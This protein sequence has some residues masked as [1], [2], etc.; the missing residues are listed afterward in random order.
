MLLYSSTEKENLDTSA[1][2]ALQSNFPNNSAKTHVRKTS[3][4]WEKRLRFGPCAVN[5]TWEGNWFALG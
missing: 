4:P 1:V 5:L 3:S 2:R